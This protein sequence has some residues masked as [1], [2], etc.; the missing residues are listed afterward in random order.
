M[1]MAYR[2]TPSHIIKV[3]YLG[4][5]LVLY[6][7]IVHEL[8]GQARFRFSPVGRAA[9]ALVMACAAWPL[10]AQT[11]AAPAAEQQT[12]QKAAPEADA[13]LEVVSVVGDWLADASEEDVFAHP[14][15]RDVLRR[16]EFTREGIV[17]VREALNRIPGVNAPE[18]NGTGSHDM[19]LNF[20][21]RGLNPRLASRS[22]VLMDGIPV[23]FAPYGQPQLSFGA[24]TMGNVDALDVVRGGG[25]VRNL[26]D[27][28]SVV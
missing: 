15:A 23:P 3:N 21:V 13:T 24:V 10:A 7:F 6:L 9:L 4:G 16:E 8:S 20:G 28:K 2:A 17:T 18:N 11:A 14:G 1:N 25:A 12:E 22:T 27:R 26:T 19:A 5:L